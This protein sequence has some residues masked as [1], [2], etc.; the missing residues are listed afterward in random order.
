MNYQNATFPEGAVKVGFTD[1]TDNLVT[2]GQQPGE[3]FI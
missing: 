1:I 3:D 2:K